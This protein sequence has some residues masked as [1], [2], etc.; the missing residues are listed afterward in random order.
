MFILFVRVMDRT[1][2]IGVAFSGKPLGS[3]Y[4]PIDKCFVSN[5]IDM[6]VLVKNLSWVFTHCDKYD[7]I[8][9]YRCAL[10]VR[11]QYRFLPFLEGGSVTV[12]CAMLWATQKSWLWQST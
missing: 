6:C 8:E 9:L 2:S 11:N 12:L 7:W 1:L 10:L 5:T 4:T 3:F